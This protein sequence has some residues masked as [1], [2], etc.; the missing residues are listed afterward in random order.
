RHAAGHAQVVFEHCEP[1]VA[2]PHQVS[3]DYGDINVT[4]HADS[5]H[6]AAVVFATVYQFARHDSVVQDFSVVINVF[7]EEVERRDALR[8]S[9]I[10][11]G[12][13]AGSDDAGQQV[14]RKNLLRAFV[15][16]VNGESDSLVEETY[17]GGLLPLLQ[18]GRSQFQQ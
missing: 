6:L 10:N 12:P 8:Q 11:R 3:A 15:V 18:F 17:V 5:S 14:V 2:Q 16:A 1:P 9:F 13:F 4:P 7:K